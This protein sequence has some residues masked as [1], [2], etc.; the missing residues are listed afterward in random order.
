MPLLRGPKIWPREG[1]GLGYHLAVLV[2]ATAV[3]LLSLSLYLFN[4]T[5][6]NERQSIRFALTTNAQ[7]LAAL[8]DSEIDTHAPSRK[9]CRARRL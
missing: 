3:P 6:E 4:R 7:T 8:V 5:V 1:V 9:H 2:V